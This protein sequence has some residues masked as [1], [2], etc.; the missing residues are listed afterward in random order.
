[1]KR[2]CRRCIVDA[3]K[4]LSA[5]KVVENKPPILR[6]A[7]DVL[8]EVKSSCMN[9][10]DKR[11]AD[12]YGHQIL[13]SLRYA[14]SGCFGRE[15]KSELPLVLGRDFSGVV[16][17]A[18][19]L[20]SK[21]FRLGTEVFGATFP[22]HMGTHQEYVAVDASCLTKKPKSIDHRLAGCVAYAGL[23]A[24]AGLVT[25]G[26][27][28]FNSPRKTRL[29]VLGASG[30][31]GHTATQLG[32]AGQA[33]VTAVAGPESEESVKASGA[34]YLNY[35]EPSYAKDLISLSGFDI[36][37]DCAGFGSE[38]VNLAPLLRS[39]GCVVTMDSPVLNHTDTQGIV[40]G[41]LNSVCDL[42][43]SNLKLGAGSLST[44]NTV[45]WAYFL[46]DKKALEFLSELLSDKS[47]QPTIDK[48]FHFK[49]I[50]EAY[51]YYETNRVK[52]KVAIN[53]SD[54]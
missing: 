25:T 26:G 4:G 21:E 24:W 31:V 10:L 38:A 43:N 30:G 12:G 28:Q 42:I 41:G 7:N 33:D 3:Y 1:M 46:P 22:S 17:D 19:H 44:G 35:K 23:S 6:N 32:L 37:L 53:M 8:V 9:P 13:N 50:L 16:V 15:Y 5:A 49:D 45:R 36:V 52:G 27:F 34:T 48:T 11:M 20:A 2:H 51:A 40:M 39:G 47:L 29:L 54:N 18:G 14:E